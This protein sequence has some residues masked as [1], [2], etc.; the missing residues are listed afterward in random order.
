MGEEKDPGPDQFFWEA[1][2]N[3]AGF[4]WCFMEGHITWE[5][6]TWVQISDPP[7]PS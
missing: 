7:F 1:K 5:A 3:L 2:M 6:W 4:S